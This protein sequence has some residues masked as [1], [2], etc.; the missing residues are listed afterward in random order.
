MQ[1]GEKINVDGLTKDNWQRKHGEDF[2]ILSLVAREEFVK[3]VVKYLTLAH[4]GA[5]SREREEMSRWAKGKFDWDLIA[6]QWIRYFHE[7]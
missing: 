4:R 6:D 1:Y 7:N 3:A 2:G 5:W